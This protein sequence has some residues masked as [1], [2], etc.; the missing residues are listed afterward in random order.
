VPFLTTEAIEAAYAICRH[1]WL[2]KEQ[3]GKT[4][5]FESIVE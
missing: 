2:G 1:D 4:R 5:K 3:G